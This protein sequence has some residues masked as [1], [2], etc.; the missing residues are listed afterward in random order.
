MG[1]TCSCKK[2]TSKRDIEIRHP[3]YIESRTLLC[4]TGDVSDIVE[5]SGWKPHFLDESFKW[6]DGLVLFEN[7]PY[8]KTRSVV[9]GVVV[10]PRAS[11][12]KGAVVVVG[13]YENPRCLKMGLGAE[14]M[15]TFLASYYADNDMLYDYDGTGIPVPLIRSY[16]FNLPSVGDVDKYSYPKDARLTRFIRKQRLDINPIAY[17]AARGTQ[18]QPSRV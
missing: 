16:G 15:R 7:D 14:A 4:R 2:A 18:E 13:V 3:Y 9:A 12:A 1:N 17:F 10:D 6:T 5:T 8:T 11:V